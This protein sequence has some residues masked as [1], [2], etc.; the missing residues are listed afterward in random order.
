MGVS[1][2]ITYVELYIFLDFSCYYHQEKMN[3]VEIFFN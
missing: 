2:S 3:M 1:S